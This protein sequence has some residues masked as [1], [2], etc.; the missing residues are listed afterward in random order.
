MK[1]YVKCFKTY[2]MNIVDLRIVSF[3]TVKN[4]T[5]SGGSGTGYCHYK[6]IK[7][8]YNN[9]SSQEVIIDNWYTQKSEQLKQ[10]KDHCLSQL[11]FGQ[12]IVIDQPTI[13]M[14]FECLKS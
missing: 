7:I 2:N 12:Y 5:P 10:L 4:F 8:T 9:G 11:S 14:F 13:D 3:E 1:I 6:K